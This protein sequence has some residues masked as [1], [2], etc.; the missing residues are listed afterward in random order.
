MRRTQPE[1]GALAVNVTVTQGEMPNVGESFV[2]VCFHLYGTAHLIADV[3]GTSTTSESG[4][5]R[6]RAAD[7][8]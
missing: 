7:D 6:R 1:V 3:S 2:M 4:V 8:R 5:K